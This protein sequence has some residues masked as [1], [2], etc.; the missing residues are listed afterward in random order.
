[1][2]LNPIVSIIIPVYNASETVESVLDALLSQSYPDDRTELIIVDNGSLDET[3]GIVKNYPV[4]LLT[5]DSSRSPYTARN[6][7]IKESAG[8][9]IA[10]TDANKI[11]DKNWVEEGVAAL[12][13]LDA[14]L[15]GGDIQFTIGENPGVAEIYDSITFNNNRNLVKHEKGAACGNLF[16]KR[17]VIEKIGL[18]PG[19]IRSG[20]DIWW[21]QKAVE[22]GFKLVFAEKAVVRCVPRKFPSVIKKSYRVG[23]SHPINMKSRGVSSPYI[24]WTAIK[25]LSPPRLSNLR[26]KMNHQLKSASLF[27]LWSTAWISKIVMATGRLYGLFFMKSLSGPENYKGSTKNDGVDV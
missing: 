4:T 12:E 3:P 21:T 18:F 27:K 5:E 23:V 26:E 1:M 15:S 19:N 16:V 6:V 8:Q 7:G 24:L 22:S 13:S 11:P 14:D 9:I 2:D 20:M 10:F 25:T 17:E